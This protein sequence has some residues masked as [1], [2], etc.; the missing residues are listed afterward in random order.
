MKQHLV[1]QLLCIMITGGEIRFS[2]CECE[3]LFTKVMWIFFSWCCVWSC[4]KQNK[5]ENKEEEDEDFSGVR[6]WC[7]GLNRQHPH[8]IKNPHSC[9]NK[10]VIQSSI[11]RKSSRFHTWWPRKFESDPVCFSTQQNSFSQPSERLEALCCLFIHVAGG[12]W[13]GGC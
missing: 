12:L 1:Q 7:W 9:S 4:S 11:H 2:I 13:H 3:Q 10:S 8:R 6:E 5:W